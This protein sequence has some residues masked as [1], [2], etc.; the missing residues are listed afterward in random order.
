M[1]DPHRDQDADPRDESGARRVDRDADAPVA[2]TWEFRLR[3]PPSALWPLLADT[4]RLF[5]A[6]E[7]PRFTLEPDP[8]GGAPIACGAEGSRGLEWREEPYEWVAGQWWRFERRF[9]KG[10]LSRLRATLYLQ[11]SLAGGSLLN[12][13]LEAEP[14]GGIGRSLLSAGYLRRLGEGLQSCAEHVDA[15]LCG[16]AGA[17]Y[18]VRARPESRA[19]AVAVEGPSRALAA[20]PY[21]NGGAGALSDLLTAAPDAEVAEIRVRRLARLIDLSERAAAEL[22]LGAV[23]HG[24]MRL[25]LVVLCPRCRAVVA[26]AGSFAELPERARCAR[27]G[28]EFAVD[29]AVNVEALFAAAPEARP[30]APGLFC[31]SGPMTAPHVLLQQR[32]EPGER[33]GFPFEPRA[34]G[35]RIVAA[36]DA[37]GPEE[38]MVRPEEELDPLGDARPRRGRAE[39]TVDHIGGPFP[40]V[41]ATF[42]GIAA[43]G[44]PEDA[45]VVF[46][47]HADQPL[48][49]GLERREWRADALTAAELAPLQAYRA[50]F[51]ADAPVAPV[52]A[53]WV[54]FCAYIVSERQALYARLGDAEATRRIDR[55]RVRAEELARARNGGVLRVSGERGLA[56]FV[57]AVDAAR[58]ALELREAATA[59]L[60][61][62]EAA[63]AQDPAAMSGDAAFPDF[64]A[65]RARAPRIACGLAA[66]RAIA[67]ARQGRLDYV[68]YAAALAER[69]SEAA[70]GGEILLSAELAETVAVAD[71]LAPYVRTDDALPAAEFGPAEAFARIGSREG[72]LV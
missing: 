16:E 64:E 65:A 63:A 52:R 32:L 4:N 58:F 6:L 41:A 15:F 51:P 33:R 19:I 34:G 38:D 27:D 26:E 67:M 14:N 59:V 29:L 1:D 47:N 11:R 43:G 17:P 7:M 68:G 60:L 49:L 22:C 21:G 69:F 9:R 2:E 56:A 28:L 25:R 37:P 12:F 3:Q 44:P 18:P 50:L 5:E 10:P 40:V 54:A 53:G 62:E 30:V 48:L 70:V 66:G 35:Y 72:D 57:D 71:L 45:G 39:Q 31:A 13:A 61:G 46:E 42:D 8:L 24:L 36:P 20:S 55:L 23:S